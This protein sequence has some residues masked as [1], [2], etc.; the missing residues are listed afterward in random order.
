MV[1]ATIFFL[2]LGHET[3]CYQQK[4]YNKGTKE[5]RERCYYKWVESVGTMLLEGVPQHSGYERY[6]LTVEALQLPFWDFFICFNNAEFPLVKEHQG[7]LLHIS[8]TTCL[9]NVWPMFSFHAKH[10]DP[11]SWFHF[12]HSMKIS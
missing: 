10:T 1:I 2:D 4:V 8:G 5:E 7:Y 3:S 9:G 6:W 11:I 12:T